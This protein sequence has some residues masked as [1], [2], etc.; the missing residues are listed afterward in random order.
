MK[1]ALLLFFVCGL[2]FLFYSLHIGKTTKA[3]LD[4]LHHVFERDE[5]TLS[6]Y[7]DKYEETNA[8]YVRISNLANGFLTLSI[9]CFIFCKILGVKQISDF[10]GVRTLSKLNVL[11]YQM[12]YG[13]CFFLGHG[14][15][16]LIGYGEAIILLIRIV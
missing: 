5:I 8:L 16:I 12:F 14:S 11:Y 4:E 15:F 3:N 9:F 2:F 7:N 10:K 6:E 13:R 1:K